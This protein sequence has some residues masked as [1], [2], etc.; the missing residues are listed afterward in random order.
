M[1]IAP[2]TAQ[3]SNVGDGCSGVWTAD[4]SAQSPCMDAATVVATATIGATVGIEAIDAGN[5]A[6]DDL[7]GP[8]SFCLR[9]SLRDKAASMQLARSH[10]WTLTPRE[11]EFRRLARGNTNKHVAREL[12]C[13]ERTV[14]AHRQTVMEKNGGPNSG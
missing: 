13:T 1:P 5:Y 12:G 6:T 10:F 2:L 4:A 7:S 14:K 8:L 9:K 3:A 11:R